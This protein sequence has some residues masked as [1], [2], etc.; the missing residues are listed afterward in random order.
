LM[1]LDRAITGASEVVQAFRPAVTG[2]P[3]GSHYD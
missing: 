1:S 2:G 3:K